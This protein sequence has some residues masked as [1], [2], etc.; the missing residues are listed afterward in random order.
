V[1][2]LEL[3]V[4]LLQKPVPN[5]VLVDTIEDKE[6][7]EELKRLKF[8]VQTMKKADFSHEQLMK[9]LTLLKIVLNKKRPNYR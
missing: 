5:K 3:P 6:I 2:K 9:F 1:K 7:Y 4:E 8:D